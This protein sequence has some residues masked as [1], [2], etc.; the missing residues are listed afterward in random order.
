MLLSMAVVF[1]V[2]VLS[3][4]YWGVGALFFVLGVR[5]RDG[6]YRAVTTAL[7]F[8]QIALVYQMKNVVPDDTFPWF[9]VANLCWIGWFVFVLVGRM[10]GSRGGEEST[11]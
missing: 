1:A 7:L 5:G 6:P 8:A 4:Y 11:S 3:R 10:V 2:I 9:V